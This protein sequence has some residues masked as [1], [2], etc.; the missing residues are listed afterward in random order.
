[1]TM[2]IDLRNKPCDAVIS[3]L[4]PFSRLLTIYTRRGPIRNMLKPSPAAG[5][6]R[7]A[8]AALVPPRAN[9]A[10]SVAVA[11]ASGRPAPD[12]GAATIALVQSSSLPM[13]V[14]KELE[15]MILVGDLPAGSKLNES[16]VAEL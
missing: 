14:Q 8:V 1:M 4:A 12:R 9:G 11:A 15:R 3:A 5:G 7:R 2:R 10:A 6:R 16:S 13:L